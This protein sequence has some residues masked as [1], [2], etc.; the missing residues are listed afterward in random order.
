VNLEAIAVGLS[1]KELEDGGIE[2][3]V[4][5]RCL[6]Y[7]CSEFYQRVADGGAVSMFMSTE[8]VKNQIWGLICRCKRLQVLNRDSRILERTVSINAGARIAGDREQENG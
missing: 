3:A 5:S 7:V 4:C 8:T 2:T 6:C 1:A